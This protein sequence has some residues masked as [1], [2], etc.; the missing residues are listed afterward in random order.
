M[1][2]ITL[3]ETPSVF[4]FKPWSEGPHSCLVGLILVVFGL[5]LFMRTCEVSLVWTT[6]T[7][8]STILHREKA[9]VASALFA[10]FCQT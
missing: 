3:T 2:S 8:H 1:P 6:E 9:L 4:F 10:N 5:H 7:T